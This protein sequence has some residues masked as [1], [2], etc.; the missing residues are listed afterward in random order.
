MATIRGGHYIPM[1]GSDSLP[2]QVDDFLLDVYPVTNAQFLEFVERDPNWERSQVKRV[3][4]DGN[5][6]RSWTSGTVVG[7]GRS[8]QA[9][10][11]EISWFAANA[12]CECA[13][14]RLATLKE[15]EYVAMADRTRPDARKDEAFTRHILEWYEKRSAFEAEVGSTYKNYW[16]VWDLHGLIWEWTADFSSVLMEDDARKGTSGT[17]EVFCGSATIG[18]A[19]LENYA[20][21][22]RYAFRA[23][24][25]ARY[26]IHNLGFRCAKDPSK[27][28]SL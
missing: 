18:A 1:Y 9:P 21:F 23:S 10:V 2:V 26:S 7:E 13:G 6:L 3:F 24:L 15:W 5:Y 25:N 12:Y 16:G 11:T 14:K 17:N 28:G 19:D 20:A 4:G 22:M 27:E 8:L